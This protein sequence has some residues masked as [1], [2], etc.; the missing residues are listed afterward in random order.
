[1]ILVTGASGALGGLIFDRLTTVPGVEVV[2][3]SAAQT[4]APDA[5]TSTSLPRWSMASGA[6]TCWSSSRP[7][8]PRTTSCWTGTALRSGRQAPPGSGT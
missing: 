7:A 6:S 5:S 3:G 8:L 4:V 1:M 2:A